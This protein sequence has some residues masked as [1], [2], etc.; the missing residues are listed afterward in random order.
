MD[1]P[2][3]WE[4]R[5]GDAQLG[6]RA[7]H[8]IFRK[9]PVPADVA[10]SLRVLVSKWG[11]ILRTHPMWTAACGQ[12]VHFPI[13]TRLAT[14]LGMDPKACFGEPSGYRSMEELRSEIT[15]FYG[16]YQECRR[17]VFA[18]DVEVA[19]RAGGRMVLADDAPGSLPATG[20]AGTGT[21]AG[22]SASSVPGTTATAALA[23][24]FSTACMDHVLRGLLVN[25][26][27]DGFGTGECCVP[28]G[29]RVS[30][31]S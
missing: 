6:L 2:P 18:T 11:H 30:P 4:Q 28:G 9:I 17:D 24:V 10:T 25:Q 3:A 16:F 12:L 1:R 7:L 22:H 5:V 20:G 21:G 19:A 31:A 13:I 29:A 14:A 8:L 26:L 23:H 27:F 15:S